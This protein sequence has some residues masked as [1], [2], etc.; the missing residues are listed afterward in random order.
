ML[1]VAGNKKDRKY[2]GNRSRSGLV[3]GFGLIAIVLTGCASIGSSEALSLGKI[4]PGTKLGAK[5][6]ARQN[7]PSLTGDYLKARYSARE[8]VLDQAALSYG[9]VAEKLPDDAILQKQA[10]FF[11]LV[12]GHERDALALAAKVMEHQRVAEDGKDTSLPRVS[13]LNEGLPEFVLYADHIKAGRFEDARAILD[14]VDQSM[15]TR[16]IAHLLQAW[17]VFEEQGPEEAVRAVRNPQGADIFGGFVPLHQALLMDKAAPDDMTLS[18]YQAALSGYGQEAAIRAYGL[19]LERSGERDKAIDLYTAMV[20]DAGI[21]RRTGRMGLARLGVPVAGESR[22]LIR[23]AKKA[24][25]S[26]A[27]N[28]NEGAA[29][30]FHNFAWSAYEQAISEQ[31]AAR[32]AGFGRFEAFLNT[33]LAYARVGLMLNPKLDEAHYLIGSIYMNYDQYEAA[34][35]AFKKVRPQSAYYEYAVIDRAEALEEMDNADAAIR[36][37]ERLI[38][39]DPYALDAILRLASLYE[40]ADKF[41]TAE[42]TLTNGIVAARRLLVDADN[43]ETENSLWRWYFARGAMRTENDKWPEAEADFIEARRLAPQEPLVLNYLG[44][45]WVE[46]GENLDEAFAMIEQ[47]LALDPMS[48]AI[49]DSLG[50]AYYQN[51]DYDQAIFYLEKA[52]QMEPDDPVITDHLG[53]AY[54]AKGRYREALYEW[55]RALDFNPAQKLRSEIEAKL[56]SMAGVLAESM[57]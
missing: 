31:A 17:L 40:Q 44:Y 37:L 47:A 55:R 34:E 23:N 3:W 28:A 11:A 13:T 35:K 21:L 14:G 53:D 46:R 33:P 19:W 16:S 41:P 38:K 52:V 10:F 12:A 2:S 27:Q 7:L 42:V 22:A 43:P 8:Q 51:K 29:L 5:T 1:S 45:S 48:A 24:S 6:S 54:S 30:V 39:T 9:Q 49:T 18:A 20:R 26:L 25:L 15:F 4:W 56:S 32:N 36:L 50:W 57:H